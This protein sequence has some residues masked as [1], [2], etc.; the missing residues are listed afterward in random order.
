[1]QRQESWCIKETQKKLVWLGMK[2]AGEMGTL[3][4]QRTSG[5]GHEGS[6]PL[7]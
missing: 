1:M 3:G 6:F 2:C 5:L 7:Y 4:E